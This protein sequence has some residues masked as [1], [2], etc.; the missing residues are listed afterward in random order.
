MTTFYTYTQLY[1][2]LLVSEHLLLLKRQLSPD[3][4]TEEILGIVF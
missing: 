1:T 3:V 4:P 2:V